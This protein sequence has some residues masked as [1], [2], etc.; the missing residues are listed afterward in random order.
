MDTFVELQ[1]CNLIKHF[2]TPLLLTRVGFREIIDVYL[3]EISVLLVVQKELFHFV[4]FYDQLVDHEVF[5]GDF[6]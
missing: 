2:K 3:E 5:L 1:G 6:L 4:I